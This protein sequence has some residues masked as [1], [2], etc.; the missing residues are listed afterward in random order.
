MIGKERCPQCGGEISGEVYICPAC[1]YEAEPGRRSNQAWW[2]VLF[3]FAGALIGA[4]AVIGWQI[5]KERRLWSG[6]I[7]SP[8][9][10]SFE[11]EDDLMDF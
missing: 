9:R 4:G 6:Q 7:V 8:S 10:A 2:W 1:G 5:Y 11:I 3:G